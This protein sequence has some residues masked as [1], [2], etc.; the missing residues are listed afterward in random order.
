MKFPKVLYV[1]VEDGGSGPSYLG[2]YENLADAA[3][4]GVKVRIASYTLAA[5]QDVEGV[6]ETSKA[7]I[8]RDK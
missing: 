7:R 8:N 3:E 6:V 4:M 5:T 2:T 1:K